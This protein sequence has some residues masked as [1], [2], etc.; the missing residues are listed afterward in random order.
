MCGRYTETLRKL[1]FL[2]PL[3]VELNLEFTPRYNVAPTQMAAIIVHEN[4]KAVLKNARWGLVPKWDP[5][6]KVMLINARSETASTRPAFRHLF[7]KRRCLVLADGFY[8]WQSRPG[9]KQ[10]IFFH[11]K[12]RQGFAFAGLWDDEENGDASC[13]TFCILTVEPNDLVA[14]IHNRMPLILTSSEMAQWID[15]QSGPSVLQSLLRPHPAGDMASHPV[16]KLVNNAG[17][18]SPACV[19]P[20]ELPPVPIQQSLF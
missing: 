9:G 20:V 1:Q 8:E 10:P 3:D 14:P 13:P 2:D 17:H 5:E 19:D 7:Q 12:N 6:K 11:L 4:G 16:S 15:P 18:E